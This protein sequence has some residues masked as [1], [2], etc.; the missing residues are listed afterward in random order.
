MKNHFFF[1][2]AGNKRQ[3]VEHIYSKINFENI[4][5]ICEPFCGS[6]AVSYYIW[7]QNPDKKFKYVI[8]D[9]DKFLYEL[10]TLVKSD[11]KKRMEEIEK[12]LN[13]AIRNEEDEIIITK[14]EYNRICRSKTLI[15]HIMANRY[16]SITA[17]LFPVRDYKPVF[18][19]KFKFSD[20]PIYEFLQS[21]DITISNKDG[22]D[23]I[24]E[25]DKDNVFMF[26][27]PPYIAA[28]NN[29]YSSDKLN[30]YEYF[31]KIGFDNFKSKMLICH[32]NNWLFKI[33]FRDYINDN[34]EYVKQYENSLRSLRSKTDKKKTTHI[35]I[36]NY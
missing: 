2:Y 32:E 17:G 6:C 21:E 31:I 19:K 11:N 30:M 26:L 35:C 8:N 22:C 23:V 9:T 27:D 14:D 15:G 33:I 29:F 13:D 18:K 25:Y 5:T 4:D 20:Y 10:L 24:Q 28:N 34:D 1:F 16:K 12:D 36:I 7:K 3:E